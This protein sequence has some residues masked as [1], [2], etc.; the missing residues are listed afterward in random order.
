MPGNIV[1]ASFARGEVTP[2]LGGRVDIASYKTSLATCRNMIV[3]SYG[4][5]YNRFGTSFLGF[6][7]GTGQGGAGTQSRLRR[8]KFNSTDVYV[9]EFSP[10]I[11]RVIRND[12]YVLDTLKPIVNVQTVAGYGAAISL[13][14]NGHGYVEGDMIVTDDT[15]VGANLLQGRW[16]VVAGVIDGNN[17]FIN[18]PVTGSPITNIG[19][20]YI[21]GGNSGHVYYITTPY[22]AND[23]PVMSFVQSA[24]VMTITSISQLEMSLARS[25]DAAWTLT[26]PTFAPD[27]PAPTGL[28]CTPNLTGTTEFTYCVTAINAVTGEESLASAVVT[29]TN[30]AD[31]TS[32]TVAWTPPPGFTVSLYTVYAGING[33]YGFIGDTPNSSFVDTGFAPDLSTTPPLAA[34]PWAGGGNNPDTAMYFQQRLIRAGSLANPDTLYCSQVGLFYNMSVSQPATDSDALTFTLTSREVNQVR[35]MVPIKQDLIAFTAGQEWRITANGAAFA[36]PNLAILP[37]S[38]WGSGYLEP[39]V[40]GLTIMYVRDN[41]MTVRSARYTYLSDAY[42]GEETSLLSSH[43][44]TPTSQMTSW[45]FG[46]T[47]D[48]IIVG[49]LSNGQATCQTYQEE[50]QINGW[51]RWDTAGVFETVEVVRPDLTSDSL[52]DEIYFVANRVVNGSLNVRTVEKIRPRRFSDVRD[53]Y[54]VDAG[55]SY[56]NPVAITN[57]NISG[58]GVIITAPA[59]GFANGALVSI[60]D[61]TWQATYDVNWN[62]IAPAQLTGNN[63][64]FI[65]V[66]D[67]NTFTL[68]GVSSVGWVPYLSNGNARVCS[69]TFTGLYHLEGIPVSILADGNV[70]Y[71]QTVVNGAI[72]LSSPAARVHIGRQ[73]FSDVGTQALEAPQGSIQG[74]EARVPYCTVRVVNSRGWMQGQQNTDLLEVPVRNYENIGDPTAMFT[75]D[76]IVTMGA[77]WEKQAQTFIRQANPLPLEILD[78]IPAVDLED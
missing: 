23:L 40:I 19:T 29:I 47:P 75:G 5:V 39:I 65:V 31:P 36:A 76:V 66:N 57:I 37:Q 52:D 34:D 7:A 61:V 51:T 44:L 33:V 25:G 6:A 67:V 56:D 17:F 74:K 38:A 10:L 43:L 55:L 49:V 50:Q 77:D 78:I 4:G 46:T 59:H 3:R 73:F 14:V 2:E 24:D 11:M 45:G 16:L 48:P 70:V 35:H 72:T 22:T 53:G 26:T 20:P 15:L 13:T 58:G 8:F 9:L 27:I 32:N 60:S 41:G 64:A 69:S 1:S 42:T 62:L 63:Q 30:G 12:A 71:G 28:T 54:F 68:T 21:S 18:D